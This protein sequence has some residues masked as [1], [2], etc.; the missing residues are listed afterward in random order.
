MSIS[1]T[2]NLTVA[3]PALAVLQAVTVPGMAHWATTG[4]SGKSCIGC[5]LFRQARKPVEQDKNIPRE[6]RCLKFIRV[7]RA[8]HG[9]AAILW[10]PPE[11]PSCRH[12]EQAVKK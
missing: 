7:N 8:L 1:G 11:T 6:G 2:E 5:A 9:S 3:N 10:I 4:P 12:F